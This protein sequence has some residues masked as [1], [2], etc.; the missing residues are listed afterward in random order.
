MK[1]VEHL[2]PLRKG[3]ALGQGSGS[4]EGRIDKLSGQEQPHW[5]DFSSLLAQLSLCG[6]RRDADSIS[7]QPQQ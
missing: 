5:E 2:N 3:L 7:K 1:D 6:G 4:E